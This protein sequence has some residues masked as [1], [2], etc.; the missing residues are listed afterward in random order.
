[1][2]LRPAFTLI[3]LLVVIAI[4]ALLIGIL[5]PALAASRESARGLVCASRMRQLAI[6]W[7]IYANDFDDL[8][9]PGQPGRYADESLNIYPLGN[10]EH[11]RPRWFAVIGAAAGFDAYS[12]PSELLEDEHAHPVDGSDVFLCPNAREWTSSRNY[13]YG[14][15]YQ[16]LGNTR[17]RSLTSD[18]SGFV[19]FPVRASNIRGSD[20]ILAADTLGT[21][22]STPEFE[23]TE[24]LAD[25][26][27]D[28]TYRALGGHGYALDPPRLLADSDRADP[29]ARG[30]DIRSAPD[31][32]HR[33][34]ANASFADGHVETRSASDM[35]YEPNDDG[36]YAL[37]AGTN[38][39]FSGSGIDEDPKPVVE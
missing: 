9:V 29:R 22:A 12:Q 4:I 24:N 10:G 5:L 17:F 3:E 36:S 6:G 21:A 25:G 20:T 2:N 16:F 32:R 18:A 26:S 13:A 27:R 37:D 23:R 19:N 11:Y 33:D 8:S 39:F 38:R 30:T 28:T 14:Y 7:Q 35:G 34:K 1:M 31:E 15:N